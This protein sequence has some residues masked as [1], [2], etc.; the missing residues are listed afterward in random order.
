M[1]SASSTKDDVTTVLIADDS[2][3]ILG[4]MARMLKADGS[5]DV[6]AKARNGRQA[7]DMYK[8]HK[9]DFAILD[10]MMPEM[11]G[12]EALVEIKKFDSKAQVFICSAVTKKDAAE[13][14]RAVTTQGA[15]DFV[16][17][18]SGAAEV[19]EFIDGLRSRMRQIGKRKNVTL[20][21]KT[22]AATAPRAGLSSS[23]TD[24]S[25]RPYSK[26]SFR[27]KVLAIGSSTGGPQALM[28]ALTPLKDKCNFPIV[29]TQHMPASFTDIFAKQV[30]DT[31]GIET[32]EGIDGEVLRN[33]K[34]YIAPGDYHMRFKKMVNG[35]VQ[36]VLGQDEKVNFC[37]PAVDPMFESLLDVYQNNILSVILTGMGAD[38]CNGARKI[39]ENGDN[40]LI[41]QDKETS[42]VWGMPAAVAKAGL[43]HEILP[44]SEIPHKI[45]TLIGR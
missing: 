14:L 36:I 13:V 21:A 35:D 27:P 30:V 39:V 31:T 32:T 1:A 2:G 11:T 7:V 4:M 29:I 5:L 10:V 8:E 9:P 41:A 15:I 17:K 19:S 24:F 40:F 28:Q 18:P 34:I 25:K 33:G 16:K 23:D 38:G 43:C 3:A 45:L 6:V 44:L 12:I 20:K 22:T 37:R 26:L 42:V